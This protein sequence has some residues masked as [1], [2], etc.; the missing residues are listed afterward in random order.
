[1]G[2]RFRRDLTT[3]VVVDSLRFGRDASWQG[4]CVALIYNIGLFR[5]LVKADSRI[6]RKHTLKNSMGSV[7][8]IGRLVFK[9]V[10]D[11]SVQ[12]SSS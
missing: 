9:V 12:T 1:M 10:S 6:L 7:D 3:F 11:N 8:G 4:F 2:S 5:F